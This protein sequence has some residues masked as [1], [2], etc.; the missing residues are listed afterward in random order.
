MWEPDGALYNT[1][2]WRV[3]LLQKLKLPLNILYSSH[4]Q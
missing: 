2:G 1:L 3:E 4:L